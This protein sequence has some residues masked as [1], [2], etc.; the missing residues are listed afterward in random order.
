MTRVLVLGA[1]GQLGSALARAFG[2]RH[3]VLGPERSEVDLAVPGAARAAV[4]RLRPSLI[5][6][7]AAD[8]GVDRA[9]DDPL[10]ALRVNALAVGELAEASASVGARLVHFGSDFVFDGRAERPYTEEDEP[11]PLSV[12]GA[13]KL[14]GERLAACAPGALV[15]RVE[16][17]FGGCPA[18]ST[19]DRL[20]D[21]LLRGE[22][23]RVFSDRTLT[24][25]Y[26]PDVAAAVRALVEREAPGGL[27]HVVSSGGTTWEALAREAARLLGVSSPRLV[28]ASV[29][30]VP[31]RAPRPRACALS[32]AKLRAAGVEMP[33]WNDALARAIAGRTTSRG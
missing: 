32:N 24:P 20:V 29:H 22:E 18:R 27:Y 7:A 15:L 33:A 28:A 23:V 1:R 25:S 17:L 13:S 16:S 30:D 6:N 2:G 11:A 9:E 4:L 14:L 12:Y 19:I 26:V 31:M 5:L 10:P 3:A 21:A 8:N